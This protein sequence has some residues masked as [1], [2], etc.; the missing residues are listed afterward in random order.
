MCK[1]LDI[2]QGKIISE[3]G[4]LILTSKIDSLLMSSTANQVLN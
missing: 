1:Q 4:K 2:T 3:L